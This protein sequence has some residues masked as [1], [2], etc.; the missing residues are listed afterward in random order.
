M[1][2]LIA[3][4]LR[5]IRKR[6]QTKLLL[7]ILIFF[8][9]TMVIATKYFHAFDSKFTIE[10]SFSTL[11]FFPIVLIVFTTSSVAIEYQSGAVK[12]LIYNVKKRYKIV[13]SKYLALVI[14]NFFMYLT[15]LVINTIVTELLFSE[16][17]SG[18]ILIYSL[19]WT[20]GSSIENLYLISFAFLLSIVFYNQ[21]ISVSLSVISYFLVNLVDGSMFSA[22]E[23]CHFLKYNPVNLFNFKMQ[24]VMPSFF[25]KTHLTI[26]NF[27]YLFAMYIFINIILSIIILNAKDF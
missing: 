21:A 18:K 17:I 22:I 7:C 9:L 4:E 8:Y 16:L 5:K 3:I 11:Q 26:I 24:L 2:N 14:V 27:I 20:V 15:I 23:H 13:I 6:L 12:T 19:I 10:N 1:V 25:D